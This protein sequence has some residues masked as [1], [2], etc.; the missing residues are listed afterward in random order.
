MS[1]ALTFYRGLLT[2]IKIRV[3]Q[4]QHRAAYAANTEMP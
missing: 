1:N 4:A 2:D 3:R